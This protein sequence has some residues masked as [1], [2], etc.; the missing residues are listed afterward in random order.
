MLRDREPLDPRE[1]RRLLRQILATGH[2]VLTK[3]A[4]DQMEERDL[5]APEME[6]ALRA[7]LVGDGEFEM[8][9][10]RYPVSTP[11]FRFVVAFRSETEVAVVTAWRLDA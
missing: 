9:T 6:N 4:K 1:V 3:H 7:G 8:G 5:T 2:L 10:W 11:R